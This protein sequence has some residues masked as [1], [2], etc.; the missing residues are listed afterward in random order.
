MAEEN[1]LKKNRQEIIW[2]LVNSGLAGALVFLGAVADGNI[3]WGG[4]IASIV[5]ALVVVVTK[6]KDYWAKEESEYSSN[7]TAKLFQFLH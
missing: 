1:V 3:S 6:F 2:N 4:I 5:A 7:S